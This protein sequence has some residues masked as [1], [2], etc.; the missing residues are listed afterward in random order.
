MH[1]NYLTLGSNCDTTPTLF[2][3]IINDVLVQQSGTHCR[4]NC[5][6]FSGG[7]KRKYYEDRCILE[8]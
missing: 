2:H 5:F 1:T 8:A 7:E 6:L 3:L 4:K